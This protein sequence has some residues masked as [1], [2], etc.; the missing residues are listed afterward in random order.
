MHKNHIKTTTIE[1]YTYSGIVLDP[2][3]LL[4]LLEYATEHTDDAWLHLIVERANKLCYQQ[5][6]EYPLGM[7]DYP[8]LIAPVESTNGMN[9]KSLYTESV[10]PMETAEPVETVEVPMVPT[11]A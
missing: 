6:C 8:S 1:H 5:G 9:S 4:R 11:E 7:L 2:A 10:E 3:L